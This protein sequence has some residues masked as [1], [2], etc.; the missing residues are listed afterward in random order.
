MNPN[1][2]LLTVAVVPPEAHQENNR[3]IPQPRMPSQISSIPTLSMAISTV[4][5]WEKSLDVGIILS[6]EPEKIQ[7]HQASPRHHSENRRE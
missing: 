7:L 4:D 3:N 5:I 6:D 1:N 2:V